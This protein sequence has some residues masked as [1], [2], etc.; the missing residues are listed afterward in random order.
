MDGAK[1]KPPPG[2]GLD[3]LI[4]PRES[5]RFRSEALALCG[6]GRDGCGVFL[7]VLAAEAF[8]AAG[9]VHELLLT[10]EKRMAVGANFDADVA[11]VGRARHK[12]V[13]AGAMNADFVVCGMNGCFHV[14]S[15]L[16]SNH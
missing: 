1:S 8:D 11:L 14:S 15:N 4:D 7:R 12:R 5:A 6:R 13:A 9:G 2:R 16:D 10:G 3:S